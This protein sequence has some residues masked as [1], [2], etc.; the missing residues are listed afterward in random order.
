MLPFMIIEM[1]GCDLTPYELSR[2]QKSTSS[3]S[4]DSVDFAK[5]LFDAI[6]T[7]DRKALDAVGRVLK[8]HATLFDPGIPRKDSDHE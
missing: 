7:V 1:P 4:G 6:G 2:K 3:V 5:A 8:L